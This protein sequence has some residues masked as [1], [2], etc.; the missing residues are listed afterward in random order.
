MKEKNN[1]ITRV[2]KKELQKQDYI[3]LFSLKQAVEI[4]TKLLKKEKL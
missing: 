4:Q 1:I 2:Q 3:I